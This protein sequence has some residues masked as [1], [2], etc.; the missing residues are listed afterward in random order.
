MGL[1]GIVAVIGIIIGIPVGL[2]YLSKKPEYVGMRYDGR[3][4]KGPNSVIPVEIKGWNWGAAG[5]GV[6]WGAVHGVWW[7][8]LSLVPVVNYL[9]WIWLGM[10]GSEW[11]WQSQKWTST[12]EF[13]RVQNKWKPWGIV[14]FIL[15]LIFGLFAA[16]AEDSLGFTF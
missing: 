15:S 10:K 2:M 12:D 9:F 11:A 3:S 1:V 8:L 13:L 14:F 5:L 16:V 7:S 4:G 6:I